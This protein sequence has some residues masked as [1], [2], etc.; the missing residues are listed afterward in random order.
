MLENRRHS[1]RRHNDSGASLFI[2]AAGMAFVLGVSALAIDLVSFYVA[3]SEAQ[4]A[5]DGAALAGAKVFVTSGCTSASGGCVA[6]GS[7]ESPA[8][9]R[10][11]DVAAQNFVAGQAPSTWTVGVSFSYPN[12]EEPQ[13]TVTVYRDS[14]H[15]NALPTFFGK[16]FDITS[17]NVSAKATAE[18][19]NP[20]GTGIPIGSTCVK[21][22]V[23]PNCDTDHTTVQQGGTNTANCG[24]S[25]P[26]IDPNTGVISNP[27]NWPAGAI[28]ETVVVK[29]GSP[30][31]APA[32]S[33]FYPVDLPPSPTQ[34]SLCPSSSATGCNGLNGGGGAAIYRQNIACCN[35][36]PFI[37]GTVTINFETGNMQG[38]TQQ[39]V[40][41]LIHEGNGNSGQDI[42]V[43]ASPLSITGGSNNPNPSLQG[44]TGLTSSDSIVSL[45]LYDGHDLCPGRSCSSGQV[46]IIGFLQVFV[47]GVDNQGNVSVTILNIGGCGS[48][49]SNGGNSTTPLGS[50]IPIRLIQGPG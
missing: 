6:G 10:A 29:P 15:G 46:T 37:C 22:W 44:V 30:Q 50:A 34:P 7:Q 19:F 39:G 24:A 25:A 2:M 45:P 47:D 40:Q 32:P 43:T 35:E 33:Q 11:I 38:P 41:C 17:V 28:G 5:A 1:R 13:I 49:G 42:L 21:P 36:N 9:Q 18:A 8:R 23:L 3:R 16:I 48:N 14:G 20:S 27:G 4:R 31:Q 26:F 12:S